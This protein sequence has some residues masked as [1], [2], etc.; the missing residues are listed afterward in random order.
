M[1]ETHWSFSHRASSS[2]SSW[3]PRALRGNGSFLSGLIL[4]H[5]VPQ[6]LSSGNSV[7]LCSISPAQFR[8]GVSAVPSAETFPDTDPSAS[9]LGLTAVFLGEAFLSHHTGNMPAF[10]PRTRHLLQPVAVLRVH[11]WIRSL[12]VRSVAAG[13]RSCPHCLHH[14]AQSVARSARVRPKAA[15]LR[16]Q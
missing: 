3:W 8:R 9:S 14:V 2:D 6:P 7:L 16:L 1:F 5:A 4:F 13:T 15:F 10:A 12:S 11:V